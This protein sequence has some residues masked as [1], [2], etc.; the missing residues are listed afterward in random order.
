MKNSFF[1]TYFLVQLYM[2][3]KNQQKTKTIF[4]W[5]T[6]PNQFMNKN[7]CNDFTPPFLTYIPTGVF[8]IDIENDLRNSFRP[9]TKCAC[10]KYHPGDTKT[11]I[12]VKQECTSDNKIRPNGYF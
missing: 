1:I 3:N 6:D 4:D 9:N 5:V 12:P 8:N 2:N 10:G 11:R 7:E